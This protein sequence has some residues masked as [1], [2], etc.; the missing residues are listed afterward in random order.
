MVT[1]QILGVGDGASA[2]FALAQT[3]GGF[4]GPVAGTSGVAAVY[5]NGAALPGSAWSLVGG[6]APSIV[7]AT[8]PAAGAVISADFGV[9][10]LCHFADDALDLEE[11][12]A[13]LFALR[14]VKLQTARP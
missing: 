3:I 10:W 13:M 5:E 4:V 7:L 1:G 6:Y 9:L 12:M 8:A 11:F 14:A 2:S